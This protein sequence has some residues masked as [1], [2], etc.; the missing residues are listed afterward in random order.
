MNA[1]ERAETL[2]GG[3]KGGGGERGLAFVRVGV[4][5][6]KTKPKKSGR[7]KGEGTGG[8]LY[9]LKISAQSQSNQPI[10]WSLIGTIEPSMNLIFI[11]PFFFDVF[12][13][14]AP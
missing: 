2:C 3:A 14:F 6:S 11:S 12:S 1:I 7:E 5:N 10:D 13:F 8:V 4:C 9:R